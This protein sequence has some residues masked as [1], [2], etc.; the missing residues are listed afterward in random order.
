MGLARRGAPVG[1]PWDARRWRPRCT[2]R[3]T[4]FPLREPTHP[5][6]LLCFNYREKNPRAGALTWAA[7]RP[8]ICPIPRL[9]CRGRV[10]RWLLRPARAAY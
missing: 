4:G 6:C 10:P 9:P 1:E 7:V 3:T 8:C 5:P 2:T